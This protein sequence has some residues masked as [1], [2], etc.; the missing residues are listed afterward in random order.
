MIFSVFKLVKINF[1]TRLSLVLNW[2]RSTDMIVAQNW[3]RSTFSFQ[4][5]P[6]TRLTAHEI[7]EEL[8]PILDIHSKLEPKNSIDG[9]KIH[10]RKVGHK[11]SLSEEEIVVRKK[12]PSEKARFHYFNRPSVMSI[13]KN[14][15]NFNF[16]DFFSKIRENI[17]SMNCR[18][19]LDLTY[20]L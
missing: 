8:L 6:N 20:F 4:V 12:S 5:D 17:Y 10:L 9:G 11:R 19:K 14:S 18:S 3:F 1:F 2:L 13:G 16:D 7:I 15:R